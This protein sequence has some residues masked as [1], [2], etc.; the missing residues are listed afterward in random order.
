MNGKQDKTRGLLAHRWRRLTLL[1]LLYL[2]QGMPFGFQVG[3]LPIFLRE[4]GVGLEAIGFSTAL[5]LPWALKFLWA[6]FVESRGGHS[7]SRKR[8]IVPLQLA[9]AL[10]FL[11]ASTLDLPAQ[12]PLLMG[13][14][15]A[16]NALAATQDIAVDGLAVDL[17]PPDELGVGNAAQVVG[18][19]GGM[20]VSGGVLVWLTAQID[21]AGAFACMA[22]IIAGV[23]AVL[24]ATP[25]PARSG[26]PAS[27][28]GPSVRSVVATVRAAMLQP[29]M[30]A[31]VAV[32][33]SYKMGE[34]II[35]AMFKPFLMDHGIAAADLGLWLGTWGMGASILGSVG[36]GVLAM[37]VRLIPLLMAAGAVR[38][39]PQA[40]QV[41]M[42]M[43]ILDVT[44]ATAIGVALAEHCAGGALTTVMFACMMGWVSRDAGATHFT[45][46]ACIEVWGKSLAAFG[47]GVLATQL[48]YQGAFALGLSL[49]A[50]FLL[51]VRAL[52]PELEPLRRPL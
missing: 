17:L 26:H 5:A 32:I 20:T 11:V 19:K 29:G 35:D 37:R 9:M 48:G 8:W 49:G 44:P 6:P 1:G 7:G 42:A 4:Q 30:M 23:A 16:L 18:F 41:L 31:V 38:M 34:S 43:G 36:G 33:A 46:L 22:L 28:P 3:A 14:L 21:W 13:L 2:V 47:S 52:P 12:L 15:F 27:A 51:L 24:W 40:A 39:A 50:V 25:E 10:G 45:V